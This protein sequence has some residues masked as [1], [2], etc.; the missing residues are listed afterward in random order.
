MNKQN[1]CLSFSSLAKMY[2]SG[3]LAPRE[4]LQML[5]KQADE[6]QA[7]NSWIYRLSATELE[8]Y[9]CYLDTQS[10]DDLPLYGVPFAIKDNIDLATVPTTAACPEFAY[11]PSESAPVV[12]ALIAAGA[13]PMGKTNLDQFAT[14]LVGTRSPY[15]EGKNSFNPDYISGGSSAGSATATALGQVSFA[16]GTDTAGS[17]RVPAVL[18]NIIGHK[19]TKG[20]ISTRG[21]VPA[22][23]SLDCVSLL[24]LH[25]EDIAKLIDIVCQYDADD[26]YARPNHYANRYRYFHSQKVDSAQ[27]STFYFGLP[28][29]LDFQGN[30]ETEALFFQAVE[31]LQSMGGIAVELDFTAFTDAAKLLYQG[32]WVSERWIATQGVNRSAMLPVI[33]EVIATADQQTAADAF[34]AQYQLAALKKTCDKAIAD[35]DFVITPTTPTFYTLKQMAEQPIVNNSILGTYTNFMNL[36][37]YSATA[38]PVGF[39][40]CGVPWGVTLFSQAFNDIHLLGFADQLHRGFDLPMGASDHVIPELNSATFKPQPILALANIEVVVCGAHLEGQPLNWQLVERDAHLVEKTYSASSYQLYALADGKRPAMIRNVEAGVAI[41]VEVWSLPVRN[42]GSFVAGIPA[43]L[44][45][46]RVELQDGRWLSGFICE[47]YGLEGAKNISRH[48]GWKN[49]LKQLA[50]ETT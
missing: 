1:I 25:C 19:P 3:E 15:G 16:L 9:F 20:L 12:A 17:G 4:L 41:E 10:P 44:G 43:P 2:R 46:G 22:C 38:V 34:A 49:W 37:D 45:I 39:T 7:F 47:G 28:A 23:R 40:Q 48:G 6:Q 32:P 50:R 36:L 35:L 31:K 30:S 33:A 42:F 8:P 29:E 14:G 21:V 26:C 11:T 13:I 24:A 5:N 27:A 18:N